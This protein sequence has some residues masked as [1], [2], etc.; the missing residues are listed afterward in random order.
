MANA[1][2]GTRTV[3]IGAVLGAGEEAIR[4]CRR[5]RHR[6]PSRGRRRL[7]LDAARVRRRGL[8]PVPVH[9]RQRCEESDPVHPRAR[10]VATEAVRRRRGGDAGRDRSK[11]PTRRARWALARTTGPGAGRRTDRHRPAVVRGRVERVPGAARRL[12]AGLDLDEQGAAGH[13]LGV[14][15]APLCGRRADGTVGEGRR[16]PPHRPLES[17]RH[18]GRDPISARSS[19]TVRGRR[20]AER[21][22]PREGRFG[23]T[24]AA[25]GRRAG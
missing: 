7:Q 6:R 17:E 5:P 18:G 9:R 19:A 23:T 15:A 20:V 8:P 25:V 24:L 3:P 22:V 4:R 1:R 12:G 14:H 13:D 10:P 2:R 11:R 21:G 16:E